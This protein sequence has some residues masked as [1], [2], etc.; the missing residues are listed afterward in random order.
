MLDDNFDSLDLVLRGPRAQQSVIL[1]GLVSGCPSSA[2]A[3][4]LLS[5]EG[6]GVICARQSLVKLNLSGHLLTNCDF[7]IELSG[8]IDTSTSFF[9]LGLRENGVL[10]WD[11]M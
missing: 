3:V 8:V 10:E 11:C 2:R 6:L 1:R 4:A 7:D 9:R 5:E